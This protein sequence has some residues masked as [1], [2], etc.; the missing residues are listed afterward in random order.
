MVSTLLIVTVA[1]LALGI[2]Y[3]LL[4]N[5]HVATRARQDSVQNTP[6]IDIEIFRVL[7]DRNQELQ[8]RQYLTAS[9]FAAFERRRIGIALRMMRLLDR[10]AGMLMQRA[11]L[12]RTN[13]DPEVAREIDQLIVQ[14]FQLRL[15]LILARLCLYLKWVFPAW[16]VTLPAFEVR[17]QH[18]LDSMHAASGA[19]A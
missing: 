16:T 3:S 10:T 9:Q 12:T 5:A 19:V 15:N 6:E 17:Y 11:R 2:G 4:R 7:F 13:N 8:L 18:L 1:V 14:A